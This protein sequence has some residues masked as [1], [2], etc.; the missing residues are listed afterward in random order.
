MMRDAITRFCRVAGSDPLLVQGAGGNVSWKEKDTLWIKASGTWLAEAGEKDIFVPVDLGHLR[1]ALVAEDFGAMPKVLGATTHRPSIETMLHALM[2]HPVVVH[3]HPIEILAC[4]VRE[5]AE[6]IL[7]SALDDSLR[8]LVVPYRKPGAALAKAVAGALA[9]RPVADAVFLQNHGVV[10]GGD[11]IAAVERLLLALISALAVEPRIRA[12]PKALAQ[13]LPV[14]GGFP[15]LPLADVEVQRL[16]LDESLYRRLSLGWV[17]YPDHAVF[18]GP[19]AACYDS[20]D[21]LAEAIRQ[22]EGGPELVFVRG[23]GVFAKPTFSLAKQVQLRCY[24]EVLIRQPEQGGIS[25]LSEDA[26]AELL[27]WDAEKYRMRM[28]KQV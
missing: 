6:A 15:Y 21:S 9:R 18:L 7:G 3:L 12:E 2:P 10:L 14:D 23:G 4:L 11:D 16:A 24:Y 1:R 17:L 5:D 26:I 22:P 25:P 20:I 27:D 28:A 8:W 19:K 13:P